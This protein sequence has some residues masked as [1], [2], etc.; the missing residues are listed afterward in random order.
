MLLECFSAFR[1]PSTSTMPTGTTAGA[2]VHQ[3]VITVD[4]HSPN[5]KDEGKL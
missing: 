5:V 2:E 1:G 3:Q 4:V